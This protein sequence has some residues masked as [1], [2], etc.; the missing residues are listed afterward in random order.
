[1]VF[2]LKMAPRHG[3]F[4]FSPM[5]T[6]MAIAATL[7]LILSLSIYYGVKKSSNIP[8]YFKNDD[9]SLSESKLLA[10]S[11]IPAGVIGIAGYFVSMHFM[12]DQ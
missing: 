9:G 2:Y 8:S 12:K 7:I 4:G 10:S 6:S 1:M 11:L 5:H 3:L